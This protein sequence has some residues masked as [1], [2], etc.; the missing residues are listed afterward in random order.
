MSHKSKGA[1]DFFGTTPP[2]SQLIRNV[3]G[4]GT[5]NSYQDFFGASDD[6]PPSSPLVGPSVGHLSDLPLVNMAEIDCE[7][8]VETKEKVMP[9]SPS[10]SLEQTTESDGENLK[11]P[12]MPENINSGKVNARCQC[13][14]M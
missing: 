12:S 3:S 13:N 10:S 5:P 2:P 9:P 11:T 14:I 8:L 7:D 1:Q 6:P 4:S